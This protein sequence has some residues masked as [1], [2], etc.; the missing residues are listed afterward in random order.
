MPVKD[1]RVE[2]AVHAHLKSQ[3]RH[4]AAG[5]AVEWFAIE[6]AEAKD[7]VTSFASGAMD[8]ELALSAA[9]QKASAVRNRSSIRHKEITMSRARAEALREVRAAADQGQSCSTIAD[10]RWGA[11]AVALAVELGISKDAAFVLMR[12]WFSD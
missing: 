1:N 4:I 9:A 10:G 7:I 5:S 2:R 3:G 8:M 12:E 11:A 6:P